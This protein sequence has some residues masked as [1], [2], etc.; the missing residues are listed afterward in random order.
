MFWYNAPKDGS[1][2]AS[3]G[4]NS[5]AEVNSK[6]E[7]KEL[8]F[9]SDDDFYYVFTYAT[10]FTDVGKIGDKD[11]KLEPQLLTFKVARKDYQKWDSKEKK[12]VPA[13]Q[14]RVEKWVCKI[15]SSLEQGSIYKGEI[16]L[17]DCGLIDAFITGI[18]SS[19]K[20]VDPLSLEFM[21]SNMKRFELVDASEHVLADDIKTPEGKSGWSGKGGAKAQSELEKL[22][23]RTAFLLSQVNQIDASLDVKNIYELAKAMDEGKN[24]LLGTVYGICC[25]LM[26]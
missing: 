8:G 26:K 11:F 19:G 6:V 15:F 9:C 14:S 23:D 3:L 25:E 16:H 1:K 5:W 20:P 13:Q 22:N 7:F 18:D 21:Q 10:K 12:Q 2:Y 4:C 24:S 17:Q